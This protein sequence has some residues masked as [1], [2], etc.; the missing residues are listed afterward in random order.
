MLRNWNC[1]QD[2]NLT[3]SVLE[4]SN[5]RLSNK[6]YRVITSTKKTRLQNS[7]HMERETCN[8][9]NTDESTEV[10]CESVNRTH[11]WTNSSYRCRKQEAWTL[12]YSQSSGRQQRK[13]DQ[14]TLATA[15]LSTATS[16]HGDT[17]AARQVYT[18]RVL[19]A[20]AAAS[21]AP[22]DLACATA[23]DCLADPINA[24]WIARHQSS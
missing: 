6:T 22:S 18:L 16:L 4:S 15:A 19:S 13:Q 8:N 10:F 12:D 7:I 2:K 1:E 21:K 23:V 20:A 17:A 11:K 24:N 9:S 5:W 14:S 3:V